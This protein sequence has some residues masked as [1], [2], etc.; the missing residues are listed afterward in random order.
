MKYEMKRWISFGVVSRTAVLAAT[1]ASASGFA[2]QKQ[3]VSDLGNSCAG[4]AAVAKDASTVF[5]NGA[6]STQLDKASV[7]V[8]KRKRSRRA[9]HASVFFICGKQLACRLPPH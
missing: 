6:G 1:Q 7:A 2:L 9:E 3:S 5:F 8:S 4:S